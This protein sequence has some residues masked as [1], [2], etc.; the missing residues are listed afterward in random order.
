MLSIAFA[1]GTGDVD[2]DLVPG[3]APRALLGGLLPLLLTPPTLG[4]TPFDASHNGGGPEQLT[5]PAA[6]VKPNVLFLLVRPLRQAA[7][8]RP[9]CPRL[10]LHRKLM[11]EGCFWMSRWT[12]SAGRMRAGTATLTWATRSRPP[13]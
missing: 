11:P 9:R 13:R 2:V 12:I 4:W 3:M 10:R 6:G 5:V 1:L 7:P 8:L